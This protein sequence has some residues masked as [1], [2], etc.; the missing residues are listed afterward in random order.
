M[1]AERAIWCVWAKSIEPR[2]GWHLLRDKLTEK[3][4]REDVV[5]GN[6]RSAQYGTYLRYWACKAG[7]RPEEEGVVR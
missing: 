3:I 4:A 2:T 6:Q 7:T 5:E 1:L